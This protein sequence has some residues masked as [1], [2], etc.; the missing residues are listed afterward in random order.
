MNPQVSPSSRQRQG[1]FSLIEV[2]IAALVL[3]LGLLGLAGLQTISLRMSQGAN[4]RTQATHLAYEI[5]DAMRANR[6]DAN[7][8]AKGTYAAI[9]CNNAFTRSGTNVVDADI[10]E[11][12][13]R[14]A[15]LLPGGSGS[16][17]QS[18]EHFIVTITWDESRME[19]PDD[20]VPPEFSFETRL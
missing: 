8:Y 2:L 17:V 20:Y 7:D 1:G 9:T 3:S 18:G 5:T 16:I 14:L 6:G 4:I 19:P 10:A 11:W 13:N 15:C 12:R